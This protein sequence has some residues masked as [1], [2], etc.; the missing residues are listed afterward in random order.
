MMQP[1]LPPFILTQK[2]KQF[3]MGV[4]LMISLGQSLLELYQ[5]Y[6][7]ALENV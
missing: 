4:K 1:N 5:S 3:L 6:K 2:Q 7:I